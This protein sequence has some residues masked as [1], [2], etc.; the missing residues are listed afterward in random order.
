MLAAAVSK[1]RIGRFLLFIVVWQVLRWN[2]HF[3]LFWRGSLVKSRRLHG[4]PVAAVDIEVPGPVG[5]VGSVHTGQPHGYARVLWQGLER[6]VVVVSAHI[7]V[8]V[9]FIHV[10]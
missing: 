7:D 3:P 2:R 6:Y 1:L 9:G 10:Q 5:I 4:G 8:I